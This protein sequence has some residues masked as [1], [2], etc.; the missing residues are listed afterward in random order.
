MGERRGERLCDKRGEEWRGEERMEEKRRN[1][2]NQHLSSERRKEV[3]IQRLNSK[4]VSNENPS[5]PFT[6]SVR[7]ED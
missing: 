6:D 1:E 5:H 3:L 4:R 2:A 7:P